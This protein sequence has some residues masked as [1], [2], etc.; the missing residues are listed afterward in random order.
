MAM[1]LEAVETEVHPTELAPLLRQRPLQ[2]P[3][4]VASA[5]STSAALRAAI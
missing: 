5:S 3:P 2:P 4:Q 1:D